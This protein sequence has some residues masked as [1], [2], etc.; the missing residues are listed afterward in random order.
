MINV[1]LICSLVLNVCLTALVLKVTLTGYSKLDES[2]ERTTRYTEGLVDRLMA[3][4]YATYH[5]REMA[6]TV[7]KTRLPD[8][9]EDDF[10]T[11]RGPDRGGFGSRLGL[12]AL[13]T[14]SEAELE[15]ELAAR[16]D[17]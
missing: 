1:A 9:P 4:D 7:A 5:D 10:R 14:D 13:S 17:L 8:D 2:H 15:Q 6:M 16:S 3:N 12:V 11:T